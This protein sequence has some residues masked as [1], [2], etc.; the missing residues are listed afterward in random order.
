MFGGTSNNA[1][2]PVPTDDLP[3]EGNLQQS[4]NDHVGGNVNQSSA[5]VAPTSP[6]RRHVLRSPTGQLTALQTIPEERG[7][8]GAA[9]TDDPSTN[10]NSNANNSSLLST[11]THTNSNA[12]NSTWSSSFVC[13]Q[14][15]DYTTLSAPVRGGKYAG[16]AR[17]G[18]PPRSVNHVDDD[19]FETVD[20]FTVAR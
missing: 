4:N 2:R 8:D 1:Y 19:G 9:A 12:N 6:R 13:L 16:Q 11:V 14:D 18:V 20:L 15:A 3:A 17:T 10:S 5:V 7:E